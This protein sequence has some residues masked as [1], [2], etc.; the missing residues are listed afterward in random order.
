MTLSELL[1]KKLRET[2]YFL[3]LMNAAARPEVLRSEEFEFLLSAFLSASRSITDA[4]RGKNEK[5]WFEGWCGSRSAPEQQ[6]ITFMTNQRILEVHFEGAAV[7]VTRE[8][9]PI[10]SSRSRG[11]PRGGSTQSWGPPRSPAPAVGVKVHHFEDT[12][13]E[14]GKTC[15]E[16]VGILREMVADFSREHPDAKLR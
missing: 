13:R 9:V 7:C 6:L 2:E 14:V 16:F 3:R 4:F 8:Y 10:T 15:A 5:P 12:A 1:S 11:R